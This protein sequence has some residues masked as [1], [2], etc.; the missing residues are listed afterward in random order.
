MPVITRMPLAE[1][2]ANLG[3]LI[4]RLAIGDE[5]FIIE[6]DG[7]A[8]A[9]LIGIDELEDYLE[10]NDPE[11]IEA[12]TEG[13]T[14]YLAGRTRPAE[15]LLRELQGGRRAGAPARGD[16]A[17]IS[18]HYGRTFQRPHDAELRSGGRRRSAGETRSSAPA[19]A[20]RSR[21]S[22]TIRTTTAA[23]IRSRSW[24]PS[25]PAQVS[26]GCGW[27]GGDSATTSRVPRSCSTSAACATRAPTAA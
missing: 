11:V 22:P 20:R 3:A 17:L 19:T 10:L 23:P 1:A 13:R 4:E 18:A 9:A 15:E 27:A 21:S 2:H 14:D 26:G 25:N 6:K 8:V 24:S 12:I 7:Q 5:C 16:G